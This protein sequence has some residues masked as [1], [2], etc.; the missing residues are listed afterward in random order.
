MKALFLCISA[1]VPHLAPFPI[2]CL[3]LGAAG[4]FDEQAFTCT[5]H[6]QQ[7]LYGSFQKSVLLHKGM[8]AERS[9]FMHYMQKHMCPGKAMKLRPR[10][11]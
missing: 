4:C 9:L 11:T 5:R 1:E 6:Q 8:P 3:G 10:Q 7:R 2:T